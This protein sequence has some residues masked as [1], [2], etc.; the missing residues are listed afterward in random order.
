MSFTLNLAF[1]VQHWHGILQSGTNYND[2]AGFVTQCPIVPGNS[3]QYDFK[4]SDQVRVILLET[5]TPLV[6]HGIC[7]AGTFWYHSHVSTQYGDGLRGPLVVY[8]PQDPH[9]SLYDVDDGK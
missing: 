7:Q 8:D 1:N 6:D 4:V 3:Y 2:G 9:A 5:T